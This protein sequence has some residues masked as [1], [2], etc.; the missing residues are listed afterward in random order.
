MRWRDIVG[1]SLVLVF[2]F[3][4]A[5]GQQYEF[6]AD[7]L[8]HNAISFSPTSIP[9]LDAL[10]TSYATLNDDQEF[11]IAYYLASPKDEILRPPLFINRYSKVSGQWQ[12]VGLNDV[13][14]QTKA[15]PISFFGSVLDV[16]RNAN[17]YYLKL[18]GGPSAG[19]ILILNQDLTVHQTLDGWPAAFFGSGLM[20]YQG[21]MVHFADVHPETLWLYNPETRESKQLY[22][23]THDPFREDFSAR[24]EKVINQDRC[25]VNNW[26]CRPDRFTSSIGDRIL[27]DDE[28][29]SLAFQVTFEPEGFVDR[30]EAE[31]SG[32]WD[33]DDYV[34]IYQLHPFRW[35]EFSI[36]DLKPKF[37]TDSLMDLLTPVKLKK[38][39]AT[40]APN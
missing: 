20:L 12:Q 16:R 10:I 21:S 35:R 25:R 22:P 29:N 19:C 18:H 26:A 6:L 9:N 34:Y 33:D 27:V 1:C 31:S 40:P 14:V 11:V 24:L 38:V 23:Q 15:G 28:T 8:K 17:K 13:E 4:S 36:Y 7:V 2:C 30:E 3:A 32:K 5:A 39:F 37:G